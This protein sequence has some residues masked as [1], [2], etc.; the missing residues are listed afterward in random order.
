LY[1]IA[2]HDAIRQ[3]VQLLRPLVEKTSGDCGSE[4]VGVGAA[5]DNNNIARSI[6]TIAPLE[7]E[8]VE[9]G[10]ST[11]GMKRRMGRGGGEE[12]S[13]L[14]L[15]PRLKHIS[16]INQLFKCLGTITNQLQLTVELS[17]SLQAPHPFPRTPS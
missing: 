16:V 11:G 12:P 4:L 6:R 15:G 8:S 7:L 10:N 1:T 14:D 13:L 9:D 3:E 5:S 2:E 17:S